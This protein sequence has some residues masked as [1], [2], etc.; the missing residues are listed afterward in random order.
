MK[1][2]VKNIN[3][4][5]FAILLV[6]VSTNSQGAALSYTPT[7]MNITQAAGSEGSVPFTVSLQNGRGSYYL[8]FLNNVESGNLPFSWLSASPSTS[9]LSSSSPSGSS[10]LRLKVPEGTAPGIYSG[11]L[12]S[13]AMPAHGVADPGP[14]I[15]I[16][17]T[18]PSGCDQPPSLEIASFGPEILW[19]PNHKMW[20][21]AV[22]G[23]VILKEGCSLLEVGYHINDEYG[24]YTSMGQLNVASNGSFTAYI[25]LEPWRNGTDKDGRH[26]TVTL[27]AEDIAGI[28]SSAPLNV[29]VPHDQ[30]KK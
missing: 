15:L 13:K 11:F 22:S 21:V 20:E 19:P 29:L 4:I 28:G 3:S 27:F 6:L 12:F 7:S 1:S 18:V 9:F 5:L 24:I 30:S 10:T 23:R 25:S 26:Y 8:W 14:G 17:V 2:P 16:Q